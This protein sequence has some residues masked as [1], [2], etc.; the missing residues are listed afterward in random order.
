[1]TQSLEPVAS[2]WFFLGGGGGGI[3]GIAIFGGGW[4]CEGGRWLLS[5]LVNFPFP[6]FFPL[7]AFYQDVA[8]IG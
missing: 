6:F 1:M 4:G 8:F 2:G 5:V 3:A 7:F